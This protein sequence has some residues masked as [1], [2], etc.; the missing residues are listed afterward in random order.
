MNLAAVSRKWLYIVQLPLKK[1]MLNN[2]KN[3]NPNLFFVNMLQCFA[4]VK[5]NMPFAAGLVQ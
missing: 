5:V 4:T 1:L 2:S 3:I